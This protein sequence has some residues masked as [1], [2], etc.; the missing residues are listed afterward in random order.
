MVFCLL[1]RVRS[2][3][4]VRIGVRFGETMSSFAG[5]EVEPSVA[6][7]SIWSQRTQVR[8]VGAV[9]GEVEI[10]ESAPIA[11]EGVDSVV[12]ATTNLERWSVQVFI[13]KSDQ[14]ESPI[15]PTSALI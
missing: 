9:E 13:Q 5:R 4:N 3:G 6:V 1:E 15:V 7:H 12:S 14:W 11:K 8:G 10:G 2:A